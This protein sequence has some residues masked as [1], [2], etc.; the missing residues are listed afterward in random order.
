[1][2]KCMSRAR[3]PFL[4]IIV[5]AALAACQKKVSEQAWYLLTSDPS[6][7]DSDSVAYFGS[8]KGKCDYFAAEFQKRARPSFQS[9]C[10]MGTQLKHLE[11]MRRAAV[12]VK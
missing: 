2:K 1:M 11:Q 12:T 9:R 4:A 7:P 10:V 6:K 3:T 8:D 5:F